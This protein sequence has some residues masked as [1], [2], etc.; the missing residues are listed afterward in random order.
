MSTVSSVTVFSERVWKDSIVKRRY[1]IILTDNQSVDKTIITMPLKVQSSDDG[2]S[3]ANKILTSHKLI[4]ANSL[5]GRYDILDSVLNPKW[6]STKQLAI[7]AI[8][9]M[10]KEQNPL[11]V[12]QYE[13][14]INYIRDNY[15]LNQ[16]AS[17]LDLT[18]SQVL[19]MNRRV[20]AILSDVGTAKDLIAAFEL[21]QEII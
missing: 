7:F 17:L 10:L 19:K 11:V 12:I 18:S 16:I 1:E 4:E 21:E 5:I 8:N 15:T 9:Y 20:N 13:T 3:I 6:S 14:L 2:S